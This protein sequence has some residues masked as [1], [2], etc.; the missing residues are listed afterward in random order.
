MNGAAPRLI[1][2]AV[3]TASLL[4]GCAH[5]VV[6][7]GDA[8]REGRYD[9]AIARGEKLYAE[10]YPDPRV[11]ALVARSYFQKGQAEEAK[12]WFDRCVEQLKRRLAGSCH[13]IAFQLGDRNFAD[14]N[15]PGAVANFRAA[16]DAMALEIAAASADAAGKERREKEAAS[17]QARLNEA[18][19]EQKRLAALRQGGT[20]TL[21]FL[22]Q[23]EAG[24]LDLTFWDSVKMSSNPADFQAYLQKFP[25]GTFAE[26]ARTRLATLGEAPVRLTPIPAPAPGTVN[27]GGYHALVIGI[28]KYR[29]IQ[30]LKTAVH[31][32]RTVA[33]LLSKEYGF[34]VTLLVEATRGQILDAF[35][36]LRRSL[37]ESDNL[38][39]YYAGHGHLDRDSDRGFWLPVDAH[40][41]RR[42]N[43]LSNADIA[44]MVR[45]TRAKHVVVVADSCYAGT[46]TRNISVQVSALDDFARL[47]QKRARTA[48]VSGGLEPV[49]DSGGGKHS[50]FAKAFIDQ[51]M[52]NTGVVDM[53][54]IF[55]A[56]RRQVILSA[57]QTPQYGDIRQT[58]HEGG[59]FIFV[60]RRGR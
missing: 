10:D 37:T 59:D 17:I 13:D 51:L 11:T 28:D 46:L 40:P 32:A 53:S 25:S 34:K 55:S 42:S 45:G 39:V 60:R 21:G 58:G 14:G 49:E 44:D 15:M 54:Q 19:A 6:G 24:R 47:A 1:S 4:S 48:L 50:V 41:D 38:L 26:L 5:P 8:Y 20:A 27:F 18:L 22:A 36:D 35:D 31:D 56:M 29:L 2:L 12:K 30:P 9:D 52:A 33:D 23:S 57:A 16:L 7:V 3:L 43:W